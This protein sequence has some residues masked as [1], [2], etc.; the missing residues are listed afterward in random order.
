ML[1]WKPGRFEVKLEQPSGNDGDLLVRFPSPVSSGSVNDLVSM[2][3]YGAGQGATA[4][5]CGLCDCC[6]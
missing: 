1:C 4:L 3:R 5:C 6:A 2:E